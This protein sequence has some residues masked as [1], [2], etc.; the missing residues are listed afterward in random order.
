M[1]QKNL[2]V[3]GNLLLKINIVT[4][5]LTPLRLVIPLT[6]P[7]PMCMYD[8]RNQPIKV[9]IFS[10]LSVTGWVTVSSLTQS[11]DQKCI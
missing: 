10:T 3:M 6:H 11:F 9:L 7:T 5:L 8:T 4:K 1:R 2:A